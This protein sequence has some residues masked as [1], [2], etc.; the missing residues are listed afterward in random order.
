MVYGSVLVIGGPNDGNLNSVRRNK[1]NRKHKVYCK[2]CVRRRKLFDDHVIG[3]SFI[4]VCWRPPKFRKYTGECLHGT[5]WY[6]FV[7]NYK[8]NCSYFELQDC[9]KKGFTIYSR[10]SWWKRLVKWLCS[11]EGIRDE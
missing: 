3:R 9:F 7:P 10:V 4:W 8:G 2:H 11:W 5:P 1:V 6:G